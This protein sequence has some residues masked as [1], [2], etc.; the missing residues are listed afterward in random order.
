MSLIIQKFG[1]TSVADSHHIFNVAKKIISLYKQS[2][3]IV[4][5][6]SAQGDTTDKLQNLAD[7]ITPNPSEREIDTLLSAG[8]QISAALLS[9]AI[10]KMGYPAISLT[11]WQAGIS[12]EDK[13]QDAK[14]ISIDTKRIKE[15]ISKIFSPE[16]YF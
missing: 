15:E 12:T 1:G 3:D 4:V 5:V 10:Q 9:M 7:E 2:N 6:V 11:G 13:H 16:V 8:E 14:I